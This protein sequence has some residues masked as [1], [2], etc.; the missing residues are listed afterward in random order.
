[1]SFS[2]RHRRFKGPELH[3]VRQYFWYAIGEVILIFAGITLALAFGNWNEERKVRN[4]ETKALTDIAANLNTNVRHIKGNIKRD[5]RQMSACESVL[6]AL[7]QR[8]PW[9]D[10]IGQDLWECRWWTS[11][12]FNTAAYS[13]LKARGTDL[14]S[15]PEL[16][17]AILN[18][19]EMDYRWFENDIDKTFWN[20]QTAVMEP[21]FNRY[22]TYRA[23]TEQY[24]P[25]D[26]IAL[27]DSNEF[28]NMLHMKIHYQSQSIYGA[29][30][31][32]QE[33]ESVIN[34]INAQL[35]R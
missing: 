22:V 2:F 33:T 23:E 28:S 5:T 24:V 31:V 11:P 29:Q 9:R 20:F 25:N 35:S 26:Y 1:M 16:R 10:A 6:E 15:D 18:L 19:F 13:S 17:Y 7:S 32:L 8:K 21:V 12:Y 4:L 3:G 14:I 27:L 34:L 30:E